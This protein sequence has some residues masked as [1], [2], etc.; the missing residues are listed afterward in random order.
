MKRA[1]PVLEHP[2]VR[3]SVERREEAGVAI[4]PVGAGPVSLGT[5]TADAPVVIVGAGVSGLSV[6]LRLAFLGI[7]SVVLDRQAHAATVRPRLP[8]SSGQLIQPGELAIW[9]LLDGGVR[10]RLATLGTPC[11]RAELRW[12]RRLLHGSAAG[13]TDAPRPVAVTHASVRDALL[14]AARQDDLI[15]LRLGARVVGV[16]AGPDDVALLLD[17]EVVRAPWVVAADGPRSTLRTSLGIPT[18]STALRHVVVTFDVR[19]GSPPAAA[20]TTVSWFSPPPDRGGHLLVTP[21][22]DGVRRLDWTHPRTVD[23]EADERSGRLRSQVSQL[24]ATTG[25]ALSPATIRRVA[26]H[27]AVTYRQGRVL[28]VGDAAHQLVVPGDTGLGVGV[29]D[30]VAAAETLAVI[31]RRSDVAESA[32]E[33]HAVTRREA[34]LTAAAGQLRAVRRRVP[35]AARARVL[36]SALLA[37]APW[38]ST[39]RRYLGHPPGCTSSGGP[40]DDVRPRAAA[41][42]APSR[43]PDGRRHQRERV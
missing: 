21:Q 18:T 2:D 28:L 16:V 8:G 42:P 23:L 33:R 4:D 3:Y 40:P 41:V 25:S 24:F 13:G 10:E 7:P 43:P 9:D 34:A 29:R 15:D 36:R 38:S 12:G 11:E 35:D 19:G 37:V 1:I 32:L 31:L 39:A 27:V 14:Q 26:S 6:A 20:A 17:G 22:P 5:S 30:A